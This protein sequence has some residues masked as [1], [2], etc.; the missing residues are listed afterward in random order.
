MNRAE[1]RRQKKNQVKKEAVYHIKRSDLNYAK[2]E[3]AGK[4]IDTA[5]KLML[6]IP[7]MVLHD[8]YGWGGKKRLPE[9]MDHVLELYDSFNHG[10]LTL[11]D[12]DNCLQKEAGIR[13]TE[14]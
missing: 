9:F 2:Q 11:D 10:Y 6:G 12:I 13:I 14:K 1:R 4:A 7:L 3:A 8:K 5:F